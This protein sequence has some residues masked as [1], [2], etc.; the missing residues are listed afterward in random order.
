[1]KEHLI[2]EARGTFEGTNIQIITNGEECLCGP[3]GS[4]Q[5]SGVFIASRV[6]EW[7]TSIEALSENAQSHPQGALLPF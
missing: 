4:K 1:M 7:I 2:C 3:V 5:F 6:Q